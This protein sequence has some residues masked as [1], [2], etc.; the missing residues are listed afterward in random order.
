MEFLDT[1]VVEFLD[2]AVGLEAVYL[3]IRATLELAAILD[4]QQVATQD[5][6]ASQDS[7]AGLEF[8]VIQVVECQATQAIADGL[9][10]VDTQV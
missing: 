9:A 7:V 2:I 10:S 6:L 1:Q 3:D 5:I 8:L 4:F